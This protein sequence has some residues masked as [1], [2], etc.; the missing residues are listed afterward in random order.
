MIP[1]NKYIV[2]GKQGSMKTN[3][4]ARAFVAPTP[5]VVAAAYDDAGGADACTLAFVM[6]SSHKPPCVTIAINATLK[7][8]TLKSILARGAFTVNYPN[9][10]QSKEVDYLGVESGYDADK[11]TAIGYT[12]STGEASGAPV[13]DQM[14]LALECKV[15]HTVTVGSHT[16]ITGEIINICADESVV[17]ADGKVDLD[18]LAPMIYDEESLSYRN[19]GPKAADAFKPGAAL[20]KSLRAEK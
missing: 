4:K 19:L 20:R 12:V 8:K 5:T 10:A 11:L 16:Q 6:M 9:M 1:A 15:V 7:R 14:P 3:L 2:N 18:A 13:I 17:N